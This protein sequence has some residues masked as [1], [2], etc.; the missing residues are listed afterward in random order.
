M[1]NEAPCSVDLETLPFGA[2]ADQPPYPFLACVL[3]LL[4][5][6]FIFTLSSLVFKVLL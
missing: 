4:L 5:S 3:L 1:E 2:V 6:F